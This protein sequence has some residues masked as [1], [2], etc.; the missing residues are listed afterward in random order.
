M[1]GRSCQL[2]VGKL[3]A[4]LN[5][6]SLGGMSLPP[7]YSTATQGCVRRLCGAISSLLAGMASAVLQGHGGSVIH[8]EASCSS[9]HIARSASAETTSTQARSFPPALPLASYRLSA[10]R[11]NPRHRSRSRRARVRGMGAELGVPHAT[12]ELGRSSHASVAMPP[13]KALQRT[14]ASRGR[15]R[16]W[17]TSQVGRSGQG[18]VPRPLKAMSVGRRR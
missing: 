6:R 4:P 2:R 7:R 16:L 5:T 12:S 11:S 15:N 9:D 1:L 14:G 10:G 18:T 3:P 8:P 17:H 13:N